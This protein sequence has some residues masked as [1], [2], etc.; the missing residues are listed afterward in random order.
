MITVGL[1]PSKELIS[2][3][4]SEDGEFIDAPEGQTIIP[5]IKLPQPE[6]TTAQKT[7]PYL[8]W[9]DDRVERR[10]MIAE[11]TTGEIAAELSALFDAEKYQVLD[12]LDDHGITSAHVDAALQSI[13]DETQRRK[14]LLRWHSVNRI[15]AD[16]AFVVHVAQQLNI[17]HRTAWAQ[18]L[19][20]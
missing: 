7:T 8:E 11:K 20:K 18:I 6:T 13:P 10:W 1:L 16:N 12:W 5:L 9:F 15:P 19:A 17:D 14:A 3:N 4:K 2:L